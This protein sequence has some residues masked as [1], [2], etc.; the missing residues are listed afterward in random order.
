M[1][2]I[3]VMRPFKVESDN[4]K[5]LNGLGGKHTEFRM[6]RIK[7]TLSFRD[8]AQDNHEKSLYSKFGS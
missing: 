7:M 1:I 2:S 8:L 6:P 4:S 3:Y 5:Y